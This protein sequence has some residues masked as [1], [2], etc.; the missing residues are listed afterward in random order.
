MSCYLGKLSDSFILRSNF[1]S[2]LNKLSTNFGLFNATRQAANLENLTK[3]PVFPL[4][5]AEFV[6]NLGHNNR[7]RKQKLII[8]F[9]F[10]LKC[11]DFISTSL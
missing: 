8:L 4:P 2:I 9:D 5:V 1:K 6:S 3:Y 10:I 11:R 7:S